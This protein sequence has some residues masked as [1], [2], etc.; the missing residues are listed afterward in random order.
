MFDNEKAYI[1]MAEIVMS[2]IV[3]AH[4]VMAYMVMAY[5]LMAIVMAK[6]FDNG[7]V[8]V[9]DVSLGIDT[10]ECFGLLGENGAGIQPLD[11]RP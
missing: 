11:I 7:K 2:C 8:G 10:G 4:V 1:V 3:M 5:M 6:V 9:H